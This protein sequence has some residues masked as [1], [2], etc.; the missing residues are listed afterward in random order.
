MRLSTRLFIG[1]FSLFIL[2]VTMTALLDIEMAYAFS[3]GP[4]D[5]KTGAPGENNCTQCHS[6]FPLD[7]GAGGWWEWNFGELLEYDA[8]ETY[9]LTFEIFDPQAMRWGFEITFID[10]AGDQAGILSSV[11][12]NTQVSSSVQGGHLRQYGKQTSAGTASGTADGTTWDMTW[13]APASGAGAVT[14]YGMANAA[15]NNGSS[16]GDYIYSMMVELGES[17][18]AAGS[19]PLAAILKPNF[20]N[21]FNPKTNVAFALEQEATVKL[22]IYDSSGRLVKVL[23]A[24]LMGAGE[25]SLEWDGRDASGRS[26]ASGTY[27]ARLQGEGGQDLDAAHKMTLLK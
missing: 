2:L 20:P 21:P 19:A 9:N 10:A 11:D 3:N 14:L 1:L 26:S 17:A 4:Q 16:S 5:G 27:F 24:G 12:G 25:H 8:G 13:V 23:A 7:S 18:T 15:N 22:S 6:S